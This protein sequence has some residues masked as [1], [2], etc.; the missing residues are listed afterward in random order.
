MIDT[1]KVISDTLT[2]INSST[3][4][5]IENNL[6]T[7]IVSWTSIVGLIV[8]LWTLRQ[9]SSSKKVIN[10]INKNI[11]LDETFDHHVKIFNDC[12]DKLRGESF[13]PND[14]I[15]KELRKIKP[16]LEHFIIILDS[17]DKRFIYDLSSRIR[18]FD[19]LCLKSD[20][21]WIFNSFIKKKRLAV[22]DIKKIYSDLEEITLHILTEHQ[23]R[24]KKK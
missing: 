16:S 22:N 19:E 18:S 8:T 12:L 3:S 11:L 10:D 2:I 24:S 17:K 6:F 13:T 14:K 1:L 4:P 21:S 23:R 15:I 5:R 7:N 20:H 9:V